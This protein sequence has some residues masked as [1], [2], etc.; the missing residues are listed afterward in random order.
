MSQAHWSSRFEKYFESISGARTRLTMT[1]NEVLVSAISRLEI[2]DTAKPV[3]S[4]ILTCVSDNSFHLAFNRAANALSPA[5]PDLPSFSYGSWQLI[6]FARTLSR[7]NPGVCEGAQN[8][9]KPPVLSGR[10]TNSPHRF[11]SRLTDLPVRLSR[12][13]TQLATWSGRRL[14]DNLLHLARRIAQSVWIVV[15]AMTNSSDRRRLAGRVRG[16]TEQGCLNDVPLIVGWL[17][18]LL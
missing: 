8:A 12:A 18:D 15:C 14:Q 9:C 10:S 2:C 4:K 3:R 5:K 13:D 6:K 16:V 1:S 7:R 11:T 17:A